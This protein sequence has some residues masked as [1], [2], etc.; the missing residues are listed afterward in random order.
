MDI[1]EIYTYSDIVKKKKKT[2]WNELTI[3]NMYSLAFQFICSFLFLHILFY[4]NHLFIDLIKNEKVVTN[5]KI[6]RA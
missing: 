3:T 5:Q 1:Q 2:E 4:Q 6:I